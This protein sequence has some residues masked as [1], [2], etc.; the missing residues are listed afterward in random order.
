MPP[1]S[2]VSESDK[3]CRATDS[4]LIHAIRNGQVHALGELYD[5]HAQFVYGLALKILTRPEE[6]EEVTQDVFLKLWQRDIYNASRG[7]VTQF[8]SVM[9]RSRAM[10]RLRSRGSRLRFLQRLQRSSNPTSTNSLP[11]DLAEIRERSRSVKAALAQ[12]PAAEREVL[13]LSYFEGL[14]QSEIAQRLDI[15]LGTVKSRSRQGLQKLRPF[16]HDHRSS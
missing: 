2:P 1:D 9:T 3:F 15:P 13:E 4:E 8:L 14:S 6:A 16:L 7:T 12:I 11:L 5:R 10:D